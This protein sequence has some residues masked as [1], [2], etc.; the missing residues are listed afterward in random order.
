LEEMENKYN[1]QRK[2]ERETLKDN[3]SKTGIKLE[4][5]KRDKLQAQ[6]SPA[7]LEKLKILMEEIEADIMQMKEKQKLIYEDL[8]MEEK[9]LSIEIESCNKKF[10]N[11]SNK[12][13]P[14][15]QSAI[16]KKNEEGKDERLPEEVILFEKF[17]QVTNGHQG[18]WDDIDHQLFVKL[19]KQ[20]K[21]P[22][23][24]MEKALESIPTHTENEIKQHVE[25]YQQYTVL[26]EKK[27]EAIR[28]WKKNKTNRKDDMLSNSDT[29]LGEREEME[30]KK[31]RDEMFERERQERILQLQKWKAM[32]TEEEEMKRNNEE[33]LKDE[34][35]NL[36]IQKLMEEKRR[37]ET[38]IQI[39]EYKLKRR[40]EEDIMQQIREDEERQKRKQVSTL[41][42]ERIRE[43]NERIMDQKKTKQLSAQVAEE[44][45][46]ERLRKLKG[47][48]N[49]HVERDPN[50]L[51]EP[52]EGWK[53][54]Q[55][56]TENNRTKADHMI[57]TRGLP[58][59]AVPSW[60]QG[61]P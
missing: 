45:K 15:P 44:E 19:Q 35:E 16:K 49:I 14:I 1:S 43:R 28:K 5:F 37:L 52:T 2:I 24:F 10:D 60:R 34:R 26:N 11:W 36:K 29:T 61:I 59:R 55:N 38:K 22:S 53:R 31:K 39:Q 17:V 40:E 18:G 20:Y 51:L 58:H 25:W 12:T 47:R 6:K 42:K 48:V 3:L 54:R 13:L 23:Q 21:K 46:E 4:R 9:S 41:E 57:G 33:I 30:K 8:M 50:R 56:D 27:R 7:N 32:K